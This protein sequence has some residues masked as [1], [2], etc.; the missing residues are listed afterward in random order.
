MLSTSPQWSPNPRRS[1]IQQ[2]RPATFRGRSHPLASSAKKLTV[3]TLPPGSP[4]PRHKFRK[5]SPTRRSE[6]VH[7]ET[8]CCFDM[9][10][11]VFSRAGGH[12]PMRKPIAVEAFSLSAR[13]MTLTPRQYLR[14]GQGFGGNATTRQQQRLHRTRAARASTAHG[15]LRQATAPSPPSAGAFRARPNP[16]NTSLRSFYERGDLPLQ[17]AHAG[18]TNRLHVRGQRG[19]HAAMP[20]GRHHRCHR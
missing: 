12:E 16:P 20:I 17:I 13:S 6:D 8:G 1:P 10:R 5:D 9:T 19:L 3:D 11:R 2:R 7:S 14:R 18:V 4:D 15:R